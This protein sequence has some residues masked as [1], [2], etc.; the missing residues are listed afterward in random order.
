MKRNKHFVINDWKIKQDV[1]VDSNLITVR[2]MKTAETVRLF[3]NVYNDVNVALANEF[4]LFCEKIGIDF[5]EVMKVVNTHPYCHLP[6]PGIVGSHISDDSY[7]LTEE[8][9]NV[10][11]KLLMTELARK[12]NK[13]MLRHTIRLTRFALQQCG[14][15]FRRAKISIF[16]VS[17]R[18]NV[19]DNRGSTTKE[20]INMFRKRGGRISVYDSLFTYKELKEL[21]YPAERTLTKT[22][23]SSDCVV[24]AVGHEKFKRLNLRRIKILAKKPAAIV[25]MGR[26]IDA[27]RAE[28]EGF[29]YRGVGRSVL[30]SND[31]T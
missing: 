13:E 1:R 18:P 12:I 10:N 7:L 31:R 28:R 16:G 25:D 15:T 3:G 20:L 4:A 14:K 19:K 24:I 29:I 2:D 27:G 26:V 11:A 21:G 23:E 9:E 5:L 17:N 30:I 22:V 8:A 6:F